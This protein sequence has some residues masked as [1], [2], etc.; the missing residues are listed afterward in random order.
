L[1]P[2]TV[3][4]MLR[5]CTDSPGQWPTVEEWQDQL[6]SLAGPMTPPPPAR[7]LAAQRRRARWIAVALAAL[8][9]ISV[10]VLVLAPRWWDAV[11]DDGAVGAAGLEAAQRL[12]RS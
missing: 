4:L 10:A 5:S 1:P 2:S 7:Q 11:T 9:L 3:A 8:V 6:S 12:E